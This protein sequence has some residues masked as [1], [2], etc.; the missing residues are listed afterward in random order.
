MPVAARNRLRVRASEGARIA[1]LLWRQALVSRLR[2]RL[3]YVGL[4]I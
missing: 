4:R 3:G 1:L 2:R